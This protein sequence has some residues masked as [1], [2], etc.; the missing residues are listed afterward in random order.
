[1]VVENH[2]K[3]DFRNKKHKLSKAA[4]VEF[5]SPVVREQVYEV[6][7]ANEA[8]SHKFVFNGKDVSFARNLSENAVA[9]NGVLKAVDRVLKED[10]RYE[11]NTVKIVL[12]SRMV[13]VGC[14]CAYKQGDR[15]LGQFLAPFE[16]MSLPERTR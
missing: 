12:E 11:L 8:G 14:V 5:A 2:Y 10:G 3:S 9:R 6:L 15:D 13:T 7:K 16:H 1:M 4:F